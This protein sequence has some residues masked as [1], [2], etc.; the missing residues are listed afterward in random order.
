MPAASWVPASNFSGTGAQTA[1]CSVTESI[2]SPPVRNGRERSSSSILP[3]STP[4]PMGP[5]ALWAEK[6]KKS[7]PS[8]ATSTAM[9]G[10]DCAPST[11]T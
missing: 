8:S 3:H 5:S 1:P 7:A 11:T 10:T 4:T 6:A 9:C 2:I